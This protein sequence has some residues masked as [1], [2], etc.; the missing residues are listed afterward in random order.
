MNGRRPGAYLPH[1]NRM[2]QHE[3]KGSRTLVY[4]IDAA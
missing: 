4:M 3:R 2:M 1:V